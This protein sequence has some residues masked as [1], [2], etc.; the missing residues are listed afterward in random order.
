MMVSAFIPSRHQRVPVASCRLTVLV[1]DTQ[2]LVCFEGNFVV[3]IESKND[4][5]LL[6]PRSCMY[7]SFDRAIV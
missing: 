5:S 3:V 2:H 7:Q 1:F 6:S 4:T